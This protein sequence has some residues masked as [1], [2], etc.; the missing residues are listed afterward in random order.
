MKEIFVVMAG[1][2]PICGYTGESAAMVH[3]ELA[4]EWAAKAKEHGWSPRE[5]SVKNPYDPEMDGA[6][7]K[8]HYARI[9]IRTEILVEGA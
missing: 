5:D 7:T 4:T 1:D 6:K 8:Y 9:E 2:W 3:A